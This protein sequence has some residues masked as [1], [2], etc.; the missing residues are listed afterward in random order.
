M[1]RSWI[2][3]ISL[4]LGLVSAISAQSNGNIRL[5]HVAV[6]VG[7]M[8][9]YIDDTLVQSDLDYTNVT[10]WSSVATGTVTV[11]Y[12]TAGSDLSDEPI[13]EVELTVTE[14]SWQTVALI[15]RFDLDNVTAHVIA[16][17][18]TLAGDGLT[19]LSVLHTIPRGAP[20]TLI[21]DETELVR[22]LNYP[23]SIDPDFDGYFSVDILAGAYDLTIEQSETPVVELDSINLGEKRNYLI[24]LTGTTDNPIYVLVSTD[25]LNPYAPVID[26]GA[27]GE[28]GIGDDETRVRVGHF[29]PDVPPVT[30][31]IAGQPVADN[32]N[33]A[34]LTDYVDVVAGEQT[35]TLTGSEG[36]DTLFEATLTLSPNTVVL[37]SIIGTLNNDSLTV[38]M[39]EE[40]Y[41]EIAPATARI[42]VLHTLSVT[43][44]VRLIVDDVTL[45][46]GLLYPLAFAG[47]T[48]DGYASVDVV[49]RRYDVELAT[50]G[51][52][53]A[54]VRAVE[55]GAGRYYLFV[56]MHLPGNPQVLLVSSDI[57]TVA[58]RAIEAE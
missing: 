52:L 25:Q 12:V 39:V 45:V 47:F 24:I 46:Q 48:S 18:Y 53:S 3:I 2:L 20:L 57:E 34:N 5:A 27:V 50:T 36:N 19:R 21:A 23:E 15:G 17:D 11:T 28:L 13:A 22:G 1:K 44:P 49:A 38:L 7:S 56:L 37:L 16:E 31:T 51:D 30:L 26:S 8:D 32:L 29:A 41:S 4:L 10:L 54:G 14:D 6:D 9:V 35:V 43:D 42:A 58:G 55:M 33:Y 40:D